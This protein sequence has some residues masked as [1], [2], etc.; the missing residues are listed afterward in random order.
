V[1]ATAQALSSTNSGGGGNCGYGYDDYGSR[2]GYNYSSSDGRGDYFDAKG[3]CVYSDSDKSGFS[4]SYEYSGHYDDGHGNTSY[5]GYSYGGYSYGGYSSYSGP[6]YDSYGD[7]AHNTSTNCGYG[8]FDQYSSHGYGSTGGTSVTPVTVTATDSASVQV[9]ACNSQ[10]TTTGCTSADDLNKTYG[11]AEKIE[12]TYKACDTVSA[13]TLAAGC[14]AVTGHNGNSSAFIEVSNC[15]NPYATGAQILFEGTVAN[16]DKFYADATT[17][18]TN[19][20]VTGAN[21]VFS[22]ACKTYAFVFNSEA[23]FKA[24]IG[25]MQTIGYDTTGGHAMY[26]NDQIG[27]LQVC[28]YVSTNGHGYLS[29]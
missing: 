16:G 11:H 5:G 26:A 27:S 15:N 19:T 12:F 4:K 7:N 6:D 20:A 10:T 22:S 1:T 21:A 24:G 28:G 14:G 29:A 23:D 18:L 8:S 17:D 2:I 25:P 3:S 9:L 13:K